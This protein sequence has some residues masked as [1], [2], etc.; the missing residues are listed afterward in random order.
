MFWV[1]DNLLMWK[2][3]LLQDKPSVSVHYH[4]HSHSPF[5]PP[6][7]TVH[8]R[9][10]SY[11]K[12]CSSDSETATNDNNPVYVDSDFSEGGEVQMERTVSSTVT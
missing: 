12:L 4:R 7:S 8:S 3:K 10:H 6:A 5:P 11:H 2:N 9:K 1:V